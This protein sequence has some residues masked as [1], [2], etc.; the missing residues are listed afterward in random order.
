MAESVLPQ[1][2]TLP[3]SSAFTGDAYAYLSQMAVALNA[4]P[5]FSF[6]SGNPTSNL[7]GNIGAFVC[8]VASSVHT[9]RMWFKQYGS[10][11]TG[12]ASFATIA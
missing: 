10:S 9:S 2:V 12:W 3:P 11:N 7:T 8:N 4:I 1:R 5:T 6:Y